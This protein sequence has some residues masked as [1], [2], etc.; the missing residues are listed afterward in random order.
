MR[1][2]L[3]NI[4]CS[5]REIDYQW[6]CMARRG[7]VEPSR[8]HWWRLSLD[9]LACGVCEELISLDGQRCDFNLN[10]KIK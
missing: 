7:R 8:Y 5:L 4:I 10:F 2:L 3:E 1:V 6:H 9:V